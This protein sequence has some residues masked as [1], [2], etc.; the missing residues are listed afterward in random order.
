MKRYIKS[1]SSPWGGTY[2]M[3]NWHGL[4]FHDYAI[5]YAN[6]ENPEELTLSISGIHPYDDAEYAWA[7]VETS[8]PNVANIYKNGSLLAT[9]NMPVY[10]PE[11][12]EYPEE[13]VDD[14]IDRIIIKLEHVNKDVKPKM[15]YN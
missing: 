2:V 1:G 5:R 9:V 7:R 8:K 3:K 14:F 15:M 11:E 4:K 6:V 13:Y 10:D 12:W